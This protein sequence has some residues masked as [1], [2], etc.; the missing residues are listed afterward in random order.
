[1]WTKLKNLTNGDVTRLKLYLQTFATSSNATIAALNDAIAKRD[2]QF[3]HEH[4]HPLKPLIQLLEQ[5]QLY[6]LSNTI[7]EGLHQQS[8][9]E[10]LWKEVQLY[11]DQLLSLKDDVTTFL[12][13]EEEEL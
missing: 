12:S 13:T 8:K 1:M 4:I 9:N 2:I 10:K 3:I 6:H 7:E 5:D 11:R